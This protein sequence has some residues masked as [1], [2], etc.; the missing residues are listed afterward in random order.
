MQSYLAAFWSFHPKESKHLLRL[1]SENLHVWSWPE[2][3]GRANAVCFW[4]V[5][6]VGASGEGSE[7]EKGS[8]FGG[9]GALQFWYDGPGAVKAERS[10]EP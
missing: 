2:A 9:P 7:R 4:W 5:G 1:C 10:T 6:A 8:R 3:P